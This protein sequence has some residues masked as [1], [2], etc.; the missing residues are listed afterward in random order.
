MAK[1]PK[2]YHWNSSV[3]RC[4]KDKTQKHKE[5]QKAFSNP[6]AG[7]IKRKKKRK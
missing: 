6:S 2:G 4:V 1:C 5:I 7:L 3:K